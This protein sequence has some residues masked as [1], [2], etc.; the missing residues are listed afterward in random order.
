[1]DPETDLAET[2]PARAAALMMEAMSCG[3]MMRRGWIDD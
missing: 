1:M 2:V 3:D